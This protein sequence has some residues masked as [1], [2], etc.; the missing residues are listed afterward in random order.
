MSDE[1]STAARAFAP[2]RAGAYAKSRLIK[3]AQ[4]SSSLRGRDYYKEAML[5]FES[6]QP[7]YSSL[8]LLTRSYAARL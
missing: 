2:L 5:R 7:P 8:F 4:H 1:L 6:S 3:D